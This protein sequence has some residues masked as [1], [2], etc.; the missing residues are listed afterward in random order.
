MYDSTYCSVC[1]GVYVGCIRCRLYK[2]TISCS[3]FSFG[4]IAEYN[5]F[6]NGHLYH[7]EKS[8]ELTGC[9]YTIAIIS[10]NFTHRGSTALI[11]KWEKVYG[12]VYTVGAFCS[13]NSRY[14]RDKPDSS[15]LYF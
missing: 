15:K 10:G 11:D 12:V 3:F 7:L 9:D 14:F 6:H 13:S 2:T 1:N 5:P 4:I 8:K